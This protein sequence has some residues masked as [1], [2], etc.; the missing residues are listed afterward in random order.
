M[1]STRS[2]SPGASSSSKGE[3]MST[4]KRERVRKSNEKKLA[5]GRGQGIGNDYVPMYKANE[6]RSIGTASMIPDIWAGRTV[7]TLSTTETDLYYLLRWDPQVKEIREQIPLDMEVINEIRK[8][9]KLKKLSRGTIYTSDFLVTYMDGRPANAYSAKYAAEQFDP[10][11]IQYRRNEKKYRRLMSRQCIEQIYWEMHG[12]RFN[13]VTQDDINHVLVSNIRFVL[14]FSKPEKIVNKEQ[15]LM[16]LI[17]NRYVEVQ[18]DKKP[19]NPRELVRKAE[20]DI[21]K[22]YSEVIRMEKS[23]YE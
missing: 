22:L 12:C 4:N 2:N 9:M 21:E 20:F 23:G 16:Y 15:K 3:S 13:I 10:S 17:A 6:A 1:G 8:Q 11:D 14:S 18:M 7:H 19:L 5:A